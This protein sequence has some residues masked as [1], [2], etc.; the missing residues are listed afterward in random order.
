MLKTCS[1]LLI[2]L[3]TVFCL[4]SFAT[5]GIRFSYR[6]LNPGISTINDA[7]RILGKPTS[8][9]LAGDKTIYKYP[10][11]TVTSQK[12]S[13]KIESIFVD[14][15]NFRDVNGFGIGMRQTSISEALKVNPVGNTIAD[16]TNGIFYILNEDG[17]VIRIMYR[18]IS[19]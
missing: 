4:C 17:I 1:M 16:K 15:P 7:M 8:K 6:G 2:C 11:V 19:R 18:E 10:F 13:E 5:A 12:R 9:I 3:L 14:D